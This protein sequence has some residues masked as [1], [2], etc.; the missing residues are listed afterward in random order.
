[1][2]DSTPI[3]KLR[4]KAVQLRRQEAELPSRTDLSHLD[5]LHRRLVL[6]IQRSELEVELLRNLLEQVA[7]SDCN[8]AP[9]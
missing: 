5:Q 6:L 4:A 3:W 7:A 1:M 8:T 9:G 2:V